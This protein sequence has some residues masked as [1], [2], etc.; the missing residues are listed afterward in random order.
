M[1]LGMFLYNMLA[2]IVAF[3]DDACESWHVIVHDIIVLRFVTYCQ[4]DHRYM[5]KRAFIAFQALGNRTN[6]SE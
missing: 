5:L 4:E 3:K 1:S 2:V 6:I